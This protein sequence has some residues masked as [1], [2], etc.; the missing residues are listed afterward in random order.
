MTDVFEWVGGKAMLVERVELDT[1][2]S[3]PESSVKPADRDVRLFVRLVDGCWPILP[4]VLV[5][6][7]G[8]RPAT[9]VQMTPT[10]AVLEW[11]DQEQPAVV[12]RRERLRWGRFKSAAGRWPLG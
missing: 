1:E 3:Q 10:V 7:C 6:A 8:M 11:T 5:K 4:S 9:R 2:Q 12:E